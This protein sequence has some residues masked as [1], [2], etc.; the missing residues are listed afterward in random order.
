MNTEHITQ[1]A[2][3][4]VDGFDTTAHTVI[5]AWKDG[6]ERLGAIAKQRWD[7][8]LKESA[9]QLDAETK[10]NAQHARA[11]FGGY[12]T[13][14]IELS[15]GGATVAVDTVVQVART[16]IDRAAAWKQARA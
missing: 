13:R 6:G 2:H 11:V 14:G 9:P 4:V 15:A 8:A 5:G 7:A 3:Q 16:A 12:Y 1:F 10:K